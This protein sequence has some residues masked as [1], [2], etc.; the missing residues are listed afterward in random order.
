[1]LYIEAVERAA[2]LADRTRQSTFVI[3]WCDDYAVISYQP[4]ELTGR[5]CY[6]VLPHLCPAAVRL[7]ENL[8]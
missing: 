1:M 2:L 4:K 5:S 8:S 7:A 6:E 3:G